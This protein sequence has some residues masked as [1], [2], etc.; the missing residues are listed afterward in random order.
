MVCTPYK[1]VYEDVSTG[2]LEHKNLTA[3]LQHTN[4][5]LKEQAGD[6]PDKVQL[7]ELNELRDHAYENSFIYKE[8]T[9][10]IMTPRSHKSHFNVGRRISI[11]RRKTKAKND[12]TEHGMEKAVKRRSNPKSKPKVTSQKSPEQS[13]SQSHKFKPRQKSESTLR[14]TEAEKFNLRDCK[15]ANSKVIIQEETKTR[16]NDF[17]I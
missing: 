12:K 13:N 16:L 3:A 9:K 7:N 14:E 17:A 4:F 2:W 5:D 15:L 6:N 11:K 10:R 1:L 8:K